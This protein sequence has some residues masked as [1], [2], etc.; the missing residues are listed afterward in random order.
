MDIRELAEDFTRLCAEGRDEEAVAT[1]WS[2]DIRTFEAAPGELAETHGR[3]A[4]LAKAQWWFDNHEIHEVE[5]EG[6]WVHGNQFA[7]KWEIDVTPKGGERMQMEEIVLYTV[8]DG[9]IVEERYFY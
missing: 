6:P 9:R 1:Y 5:L 8:E 3:A 4:T 7:V 2:D